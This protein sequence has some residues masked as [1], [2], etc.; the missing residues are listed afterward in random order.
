MG[1]EHIFSRRLGD[2]PDLRFSLKVIDTKSNEVF[3][4]HP[5]R[6]SSWLTPCPKFGDVQN[7]FNISLDL[8]WVIRWIIDV[9]KDPN[10]PCWV[11]CLVGFGGGAYVIRQHSSDASKIAKGQPREWV[12]DQAHELPSRENVLGFFEAIDN[13]KKAGSI[14]HRNSFSLPQPCTVTPRRLTSKRIGKKHGRRARILA[15]SRKFEET[16]AH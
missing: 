6:K 14:S 1:N 5:T 13:W 10:E 12:F 8:Q 7:S 11:K 2:V 3:E 16:Q 15:A 4:T 9:I